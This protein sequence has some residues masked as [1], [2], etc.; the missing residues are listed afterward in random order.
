LFHQASTS[1]GRLSSSEPNLQNIP[2]PRDSWAEKFREA[3]ISSFKNGV[4]V[5]FDYSQIELRILAHLSQDNFLLKAFQEG[6]DIH[7]FTAS[8]VFKVSEDEVSHSMRQMAKRIN[9]GIIYGM[10][11]YGLSKDLGI[12]VE[13]AQSF[14]EEYFLRYAGV[15]EYLDRILKEV[16]DKGFV[17]TI[18][19]RRRY[20]PQMKST[21]ISVREYAQRQARN[22]P[23]QGSCADIIKL[24]MVNIHRALEGRGAKSY[25]CIQIHDE[26]LFDVPR[27]ELSWMKEMVKKQMEEVY[28]LTVP[29]KVDVKRGENWAQLS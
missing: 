14:I 15:K 1:T 16:E 7:R 20:L 26:L 19:G 22:F 8:L 2:I 29:L 9:F 24:A 4:L 18:L 5:S 12:S 25:L 17:S 10:S 11:G 23:I 21:N 13:E 28:P 3:F 6:K 27:E